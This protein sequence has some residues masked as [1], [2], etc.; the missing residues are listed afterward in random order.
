MNERCANELVTH[1]EK[2][3]HA[4]TL[5]QSSSME[6]TTAAPL[7]QH[8]SDGDMSTSTMGFGSSNDQVSDLEDLEEGRRAY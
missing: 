5:S 4:T 2:K 3:S 7:T 1:F 6:T 8:L